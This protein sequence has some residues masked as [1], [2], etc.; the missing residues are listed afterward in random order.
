MSKATIVPSLLSYQLLIWVTSRSE[1]CATAILNTPRTFLRDS[2]TSEVEKSLMEAQRCAHRRTYFQNNQNLRYTYYLC[3]AWATMNGVFD[4]AIDAEIIDFL[5]DGGKPSHPVFRELFSWAPYDRPELLSDLNWLAV[6]EY[7]EPLRL[8][9]KMGS[10]A[11]V[12]IQ[13]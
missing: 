11:Y 7:W 10:P 3:R 2:C 12:T 13:M 1:T 8:S 6:F 9:D 4:D 5:S